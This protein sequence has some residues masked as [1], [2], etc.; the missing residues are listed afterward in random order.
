MGAARTTSHELRPTERQTTR[1]LVPEGAAP[2]PGARLST[3][4]RRIAFD[5]GQLTR[6]DVM[7]LQRTIGNAAVG[8]YVRRVPPGASRTALPERLKVGIESLSGLAVD[9]VRVHY[10]SATPARVHALATTQ[11][12]DIHL[13]PGQEQYLPHEAWHVV[14]QKQGRVKPTRQLNGAAIND[15]VGLEREAVQMGAQALQMTPGNQDVGAPR[16]QPGT[17]K[18]TFAISSAGPIQRMVGFEIEM[19]NIAVERGTLKE[20]GRGK[21]KEEEQESFIGGYGQQLSLS[22][23]LLEHKQ[24][25]YN[26]EFVVVDRAAIVKKAPMY[27]ETGWSLT[28]DG[29]ENNWYAE[30]I[31]D[32]IDET[33]QFAQ[34]E[35]ILDAVTDYARGIGEMRNFEYR[36]LRD[37]Y[38]IRRN[39]REIR[40]GFHVTGGIK[41]DQIVALLAELSKEA[42]AYRKDK[43]VELEDEDRGYVKQESNILA[44]IAKTT[45]AQPHGLSASYKGL[46]ALVASYVAGQQ[47]GSEKQG[48]PESGKHFLPVMSRTN[49]GAIRK[50]VTDMPSLDNFIKNVLTAAGLDESAASAPLFPRGLGGGV[51][52]ARTIDENPDITIGDWLAGIH[53]GR[54][55]KW[56]ETSKSGGGAFEFE[57][58]GPNIP[59]S[60]LGCIPWLATRAQGAIVELRNLK[61]AV[62]LDGW[63]KVGKT[64]AEVFGNL[65]AK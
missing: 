15:D 60:L 57:K 12:A 29:G 32:P 8:H 64:F 11:G 41:L 35:Q 65:N 46:V 56:S 24:E 59:R 31:T 61:G 2:L 37:R 54:D 39:P 38:L 27:S 48:R 20:T 26:D 7:K 62:K 42:L 44:D 33:K 1:A 63:T 14:Q 45:D 30:F 36:S 25:S 34:I 47:L 50:K 9:D 5:P 21:E 40:G 10:N 52:V 18:E 6:S 51:N 43:F 23:A 4:V 3:I 13:G 53:R 28:P 49:L 17:A 16:V 55:L 22:S 58:V 19:P